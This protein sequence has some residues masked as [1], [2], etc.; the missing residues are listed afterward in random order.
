VEAENINT[1]GVYPTAT[2]ETGLFSLPSLPPG[3]YRIRVEKEGFQGVVRSDVELHVA[4]TIDLNFEL[5]V[6]SVSNTVEIVADAPLVNTATSSLS[7]LVQSSEIQQLPLNGR[8]YIGLTLLQPGVVV[9]PNTSTTS[10]GAYHGTWYSSNGGP[11]RSNN[12][13][14][15]G[16]VVQDMTGSSS[17]YIGR[18]LGL[19][20]IQEFRV[21]TN[22]PGAEYGLSLGS[23][24]VMVSRSGG[25]AFHGS[26]FEYFR[27]SA[28]D[29][30]NY[31]DAPTAANNYSRLP[32]FRRNNFGGSLG[33]PIRKDKTF[34]FTTFEAVKE[35]LGQ[36]IVNN[37]PGAGCH[38]DA[39]ATITNTACPQL[40]T[41]ASVRIAPVVAPLL[42]LF[43]APN[44]PNN[45][46]TTPFTQPDNDYYGQARA[47]HIFSTKDSAFIRYTIDQDDNQFAGAY[48]QYYVFAHSGR[49][50]YLTLSESHVL[51]PTVLNTFRFSFS[52]TSDP[53]ASPNALTGAQYAFAPGLAPGQISIGGVTALVPS[54]QFTAQSQNVLS[55]NDDV[56]VASGGHTLKFGT[57]IA[58][59]RQYISNALSNRQRR[60]MTFGSLATF[61]QGLPANYS[62]QYPAQFDRTMQFTTL[63]FYAQDD[64][65]VLRTFTVNAGLRYEPT[66]N[67]LHVPND[68]SSSLRNLSDAAFTQG[69]LAKNPTLRNFTPRVGFAW[70]VRGDGKTA[71]RSGAAL[72]SE[73]TSPNFS[74]FMNVLA[75][76]PPFSGVNTQSGVTSFTLPLQFPSAVASK[77]V[78]TVD[79]NIKQARL[80]TANLSIEQQLPFSMVLTASYAYSRGMHLFGTHEGNPNIPSGFMNGMP[81]WPTAGTVRQNPNFADVLLICGCGDSTFNALQVMLNKRITRGLQFQNS[82]T[83][84]KTL[85]DTQ[86]SRG[87]STL[88]SAYPTNPF[89][90]RTDRGVSSFNIPSVWT[91]NLVYALPTPHVQQRVLSSLT[92]GWAVTGILTFRD[93]LP[94]NPGTVTERSNSGIAGGSTGQGPV[95]RPN[96]NPAFTGSVITHDP[97]HWY[98]PAAFVLQPA[99]TLGN[100]SRNSLMGPGYQQIDLTLQKDTKLR[101]LGESGN[102]QFRAEAFNIFNH[103][104]FGMPDNQVFSGALTDPVTAAP[105]ATAGR[106][107]KTLGPSRQLEFALRVSF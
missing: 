56:M 9:A 20:G 18:T 80:F 90:I 10:L 65:K 88:S 59:W 22:S 34:F 69:P 42:A 71:V 38:G 76:Q 86:G 97:N 48:P 31:F 70:D 54:G 98:N 82:F 87:D 57:Q 40:G 25:N 41:T 13:T 95:D 99:G 61:L 46:W 58:S 43:P 39:G 29:A 24:T 55:L 14:L 1:N 77:S 85:D 19:D 52:R 30:A 106:I 104:N 79:Y 94:F 3:T 75:A 28:L 89:N 91:T 64:W 45:T 81:V 60:M 32:A 21:V 84:S 103:P 7:G 72:L 35:R 12:F 68:L 26:V 44:L 27:N 50:Q 63:G 33:G 78:G 73:I 53:I 49:H 93:G 8:N 83:W 11:P 47:D 102:L 15:D 96:W 2:N 92:A 105:L 37:V 107:T 6:G 17:N 67:Y 74:V 4:S 66:V 5:K 51:S 101:Y 16:A 100:V 62:L 36:T 23:Q